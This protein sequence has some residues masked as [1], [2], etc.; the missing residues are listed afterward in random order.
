MG[1]LK[2]KIALWLPLGRLHMTNP[3]SRTV[4]DD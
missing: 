2:R 4:N 1:A 3:M